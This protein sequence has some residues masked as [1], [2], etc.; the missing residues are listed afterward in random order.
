MYKQ[1]PPFVLL[2][3][4]FTRTNQN[5]NCTVA[6]IMPKRIVDITNNIK[7]LANEINKTEPYYSKRLHQLKNMLFDNFGY[8][9]LNTD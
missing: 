1:I 6:P 9:I 7:D 5:T 8:I 2:Y 3:D 4:W